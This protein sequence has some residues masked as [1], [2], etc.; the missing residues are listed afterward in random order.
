M[1]ES[2]ALKWAVTE[3]FKGY[4]PYQS[5]LVR[6]DNNPLTYIM[7]TPNL[8]ATGHWWVFA[9]VWFN[10]E[11][12]YQ[13]G[14]DNTVVDTLSWVMTQLDPDTL[15]SVLD[16]VK[17]GLAHWTE[18]HDPAEVE[19]DHHLEQEVWVTIGHALVQMHVTDWAKA[20]REDPMLSA[21]LDWL[22]AQKQTDLKVL[23]AEHASSE[24]GKLILQNW[25]NF[26]FIREPYTYVWCPKAK[27]KISCTSWSPKLIVL[28]LWMDATKMQIIRGMTIPWPCCRSA[29]DGQV[30]PTRCNNLLNPAHIAYN[31][32]ATC[33]KCPY[34][35]CGHCSIGHLACGLYQHMD[36]HG[37]EKLPKV[38]NV[39]VLQDHFMKYILAYVIPQ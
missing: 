20:Q 3:H 32:K 5:F 37:V 28:Q 15:K 22:K 35:N 33:Q 38:A 21:V 18:V 31:M 13:K 16:G 10:F 6:M 17:L 29:S 27:L 23:L 24:E 12:E 2:L 9:L 34:T 11:L 30:C 7:M 19:G 25:Q 4:L 26:W 36:D 14:Y 39:L 8:G 1:F